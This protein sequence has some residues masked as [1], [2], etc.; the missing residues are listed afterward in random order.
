VTYLTNYDRQW[1]LVL[2]SDCSRI[3]FP[4]TIISGYVGTKAISPGGLNLSLVNLNQELV[5]LEPRS[6]AKYLWPSERDVGLTGAR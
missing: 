5:A 4:Y 2:A 3:I 6:G 1:L